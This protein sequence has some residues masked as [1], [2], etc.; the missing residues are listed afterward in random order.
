[1]ACVPDGT[2]LPMRNQPMDYLLLLLLFI[3][4]YTKRHSSICVLANDVRIIFARHSAKNSMNAFSGRFMR[5]IFYLFIFIY[6]FLLILHQK[7]QSPNVDM[8][9]NN[10][11]H[12]Y[13]IIP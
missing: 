10:G 1:M 13:T 6:L 2:G 5:A 9:T 8:M 3:Y 11:V 12:R 7:M 4:F